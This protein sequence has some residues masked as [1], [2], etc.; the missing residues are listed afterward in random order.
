MFLNPIMLCV[1]VFL[2][3]IIELIK[4]HELLSCSTILIKI[5]IA[6]NLFG[7]LNECCKL[8]YIILIIQVMSKRF[9]FEIF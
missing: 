6:L 5:C 4:L 9:L 7:I 8:N 2:N 3:P 1:S